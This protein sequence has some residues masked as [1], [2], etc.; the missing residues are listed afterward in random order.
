MDGIGNNAVRA[1]IG[2]ANIVAVPGFM[3]DRGAWEQYRRCR[4]VLFDDV[5]T[6]KY[7][8]GMIFPTDFERC[9]L[10]DVHLW[11]VRVEKIKTAFYWCEIEKW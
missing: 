9:I 1:D 2:E 6:S 10:T 3:P 8:I 7:S 4:I 5:R 11:M